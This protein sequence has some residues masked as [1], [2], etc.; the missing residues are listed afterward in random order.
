MELSTK[1]NNGR[2]RELDI[3]KGLAVIFMVAVHFLIQFANQEFY[4]ESTISQIVGFLG[5]IP[6]APVFLFVLGV[7]IVYSRTQNPWLFVKRGIK[8]IVAGYVLNIFRTFLPEQI[9]LFRSEE[10]FDYSFEFLKQNLLYIDILQ[11]A[12]LIMIFFAAIIYFRLSRKQIIVTTIVIMFLNYIVLTYLSQYIIPDLEPIIN[13]FFGIGT[14]SYFPFASWFVYAVVGYFFGKQ[15]IQTSNKHIFYSKILQITS[16]FLILYLIGI[17]S[18]GLPTGYETDDMYYHHFGIINILYSVF[19]LWWVSIFY[20]IDCILQK[21]KLT[22]IQKTSKNTTEIYYIHFILIAILS[23][24]NIENLTG[25]NYLIGSILLML[26]SYY[27]ALAYSF[28]KRKYK[29]KLSMY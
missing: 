12:G 20:F 18:I 11:V 26:G 5:G 3:I 22:F 15:L 8:L 1:I 24:L 16:L 29:N 2:Q 4:E 9:K 21:C 27:L 19:V 28:F 14:E 6:S 23:I 25:I 10:V 7:G 13:L 17:V